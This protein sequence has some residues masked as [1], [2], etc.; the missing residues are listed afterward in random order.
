M[1][2]ERADGLLVETLQTAGHA[3][4]PVSP[5]VSA[6][7]RE[8]HQAA[9]RKNDRFD[10]F[11]LADTL[12]TDGQLKACVDAYNPALAAP[13]SAIDRDATLE[14]ITGDEGDVGELRQEFL[15]AFAALLSAAARRRAAEDRLRHDALH[16]SLTGLPNRALLRTG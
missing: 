2:I 6:R 1:A 7:A 16:D 8:R 3:V 11:V 13:F 10:A 4:F 9:V 14:L 12:R 5:R 15:G